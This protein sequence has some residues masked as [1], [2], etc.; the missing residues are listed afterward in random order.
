MW[1]SLFFKLLGNRW[2]L[3]AKFELNVYT[4]NS[5]ANSLGEKIQLPTSLR[6]DS[7]VFSFSRVAQLLAKEPGTS[8]HL[9]TE[10]EVLYCVPQRDLT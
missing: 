7:S 4:I 5:S 9:A 10:E 1:P 3:K 6:K 2:K 8:Y